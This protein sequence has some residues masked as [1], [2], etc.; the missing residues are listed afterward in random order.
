MPR[1]LGTRERVDVGDVRDRLGQR[2][3]PR[4]VIRHRASSVGG[5]RL[6]GSLVEQRLQR[7]VL[8]RLPGLRIVKYPLERLVHTLG[9]PNLLHR[10][11]VIP[12]VGSRRDLSTED[13]LLYGRRVWKAL[14]PLDVLEDGVEK[15][16]RRP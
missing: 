7:T 6:V 12:R 8:E 1:P 15:L 4:D 16:Q 5:S 2:P 13:E 11:A 3:R 14:V 10:A 9:L